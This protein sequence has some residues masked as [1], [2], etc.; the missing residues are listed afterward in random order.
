MFKKKKIK[1]DKKYWK[2]QYNNLSI[3]CIVL[4]I[5]FLFMVVSNPLT[6]YKQK[7]KNKV[8]DNIIVKDI[9]F[10]I[11]EDCRK[12]YENCLE[13]YKSIYKNREPSVLEYFTELCIYQKEQCYFASVIN[14]INSNITPRDDTFIEHLLFLKDV[15]YTLKYGGE[16]ES[17]AILSADIFRQLDMDYFFVLQPK[18]ICLL[19]KIGEDFKPFN[20]IDELEHQ[21]IFR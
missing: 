10:E 9:A 13:D 14:Y 18:H 17:V 16:C 4:C 8:K 3:I 6:F 7:V 2:N 12:E 20:C 5:L 11:T 1:K 21:H 19:V 15:E